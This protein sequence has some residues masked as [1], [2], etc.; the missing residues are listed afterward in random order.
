[1][2]ASLRTP[3]SPLNSNFY[4]VIRRTQQREHNTLQQSKEKMRN[5]KRTRCR[6]V[7]SRSSVQ[8]LFKDTLDGYCVLL[9]A[10]VHVHI[11]KLEVLVRQPHGSEHTRKES[12]SYRTIASA[13]S[14]R[15]TRDNL[16]HLDR[17]RRHPRKHDDKGRDRVQ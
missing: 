5:A 10:G 12:L 2:Q 7:R 9:K 17:I 8:H 13:S 1:M 3:T 4:L 6:I 14:V 16:S 15:A 11:H